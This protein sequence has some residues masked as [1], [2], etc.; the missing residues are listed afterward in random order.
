MGTFAD[1][2]TS[3]A[4]DS[5]HTAAFEPSKIW[6]HNGVRQVKQPGHFYA[7]AADFPAGIP[8]WVD[9]E[10]FEGEAGLTIE[11]VKL[12]VL[13]WRSQAFRKSDDPSVPGEWLIKWEP[14]ATIYTELLCLIEGMD[15]PVIWAAK[16]LTGKAITGKGGILPT[17][18]NGLLRNAVRVAGKALPHWTFWLPISSKRTADGKTA[19]EDTGHGSF[20]TPPALI[21]PDDAMDVL[22]VGRDVLAR[23]EE[24]LNEYHGWKD[25]RRM[26][27]NTTHGEYYVEEPKALPAPKNAPQA[28]DPNDGELL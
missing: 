26:P 11:S 25:A 3:I 7:R 13:T 4:I 16:G 19:Y 15:E 18:Q 14:G 27:A 20:V 22:Y 12:A 5:Q 6:W 8:G 10:K 1:E 9:I 28:Y 2:I 23:G 21:L 24:V 17:Y